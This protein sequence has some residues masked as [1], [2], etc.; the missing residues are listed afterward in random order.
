[1]LMI[2]LNLITGIML[3]ANVGGKLL[4]VQLMSNRQSIYRLSNVHLQ[5]LSS[6]CKKGVCLC[7]LL[8]ILGAKSCCMMEKC[9]FI[10]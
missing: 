1:M 5:H 4:C 7:F 6:L 3:A 2:C 10:R 8:I 9:Y